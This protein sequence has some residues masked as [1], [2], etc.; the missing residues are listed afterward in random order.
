[1]QR[2]LS[3]SL[4]RRGGCKSLLANYII[5]INSSLTISNMFRLSYPNTV[6]LLSFILTLAVIATFVAYPPIF[7]KGISWLKRVAKIDLGT[8]STPFHL[9]LDLQGGTHLVYDADVSQVKGISAGQAMDSVRDVIERRAN[10]LGVSEPM[11]ATA[12]AGDSWRLVVDLAGI[13]DVSQAIKVIGETPFLEFREEKPKD[14]GGDPLGFA[15][16]TLNGSYLNRAQ[17]QFEP[18]TG[19]PIVSLEFNAQGAKIFEDL[20][21]RNLN[22]RLAIYLDGAP[23]S[24]PTVQSVIPGGKAIISGQFTIK[25]AQD[26]ANR[27][28]AGALPV[29]IKL[30]SQETV[31]AS[32]GQDSLQ[33]ALKAAYIGSAILALFMILY[34]RL[35]GL[36]GILSLLVYM[37][38]TLFIFKLVPVT[39]SLAGI[40]GFILS[41]G[42]AIDSNILIYARMKEELARGR[43]VQAA[44]DE[45][46][47][48]AWLSVRDSHLTTVLTA[49]IL[50]WIGSSFVRGFAL[51][52]I[53]G[54]FLSLFTAVFVARLL[55]EVLAGTRLGSIRWLWSSG[56][57][58]ST[59]RVASEQ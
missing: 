52:L 8:I 3:G 33:S 9:G 45:G 28:N 34:Y 16:T 19:Q 44:V 25:D 10:F 35:P 57:N 24:A 1:M 48:R 38:F 30:V 54:I 27:M 17:V 55:L 11:V 12:H 18:N 42:M 22:K 4:I 58:V 40:A 36:M 37:A 32:L 51:T 56:F 43:S 2:E 31:G 14:Q 46:F 47:R 6:G 49:I 21:R 50:Y 26:L 7:N 53:F 5:R 23:I 41:L 39:V 20:T 29:P 59:W 13:K 15:Q